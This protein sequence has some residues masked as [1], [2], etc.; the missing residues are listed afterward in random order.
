M[1]PGIRSV[2]CLLRIE[3][4]S[5][6]ED[7]DT[8]KASTTE[9]AM[10]LADA[11]ADLVRRLRAGDE[12]AAAELVRG[13]ESTVRRVVRLRLR[14]PRLR[15]V[16]D[17]MDVCQSVLG[18]FLLRTA[19][20]QYDLDGPE[21]LVQL[22]A[23]IARKKVA[24]AARRERA[25]I[26]DHR[27][28]EGQGP[29]AFPTADPGPSPSQVVSGRELLSKLRLLLSTE[30]RQL[31]EL[32]TQGLG[33]VEVARQLGGTADGRRMQLDR[34]VRRVACELGLEDGAD[35]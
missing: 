31:A 8:G 3:P 12:E 15:R 20:G 19:A 33:W 17:S 29:E 9:L 28:L 2:Y 32:R 34:A 21:Q 13:Y 11:F 5:L 16:F 26:R 1:R 30:E 18:S 6:T 22:L 27:R 10:S 14:D 23:E 24:A 4:K 35:A 7:Y 25:G